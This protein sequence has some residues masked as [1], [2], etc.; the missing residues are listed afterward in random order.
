MSAVLD[1]TRRRICR[2][3]ALDYCCMN[4]V[5]PAVCSEDDLAG[6]FCN[7]TRRDIPGVT[8]GLRM[9]IEPHVHMHA[10]PV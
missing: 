3:A 1:R 2:L 6:V 7:V 8:D 4:F 10:G 5:L 9:A